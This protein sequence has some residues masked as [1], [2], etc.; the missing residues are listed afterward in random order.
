MVHVV[1]VEPEIAWNTGN[2][3]RTCLA[4]GARLH[5]VAPLGFSLD[6]K[7]VRRAGLDYWE[8]VRP[9]V[10][11]DLSAFERALPGLGSPLL[12][13]AEAERTLYE[14]EIPDP[15]VLVFGKESTGLD[16]E[17]RARH[18]AARVRLPILDGRVRSLNVSTSVGV[19]LYEVARRSGS[20][21]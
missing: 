19:A 15:V 3:G 10:H 5:L 11:A 7:R 21:T 14:V 20:A 16:A 2:A 8:F 17:F 9:T 12:F 13:T 1:L 4:V 18:A 6:E